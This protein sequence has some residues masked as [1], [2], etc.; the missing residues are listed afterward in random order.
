MSDLTVEKQNLFILFNT[1]LKN[2]PLFGFENKNIQEA[3][4]KFFLFKQKIFQVE[5]ELTIRFGFETLKINDKKVPLTN[6]ISTLL[7]KLAQD[8]ECFQVNIISLERQLNAPELCRFVQYF[9]HF[10]KN[11]EQAQKTPTE[12]FDF[13]MEGFQSLKIQTLQCGRILEKQSEQVADKDDG[14]FA[15]RLYFR[16][17]SMV[18]EMLQL[19]AKGEAFPQ[20]QMR[21]LIQSLLQSLQKDPYYLLALTHCKYFKTDEVF[22]LVNTSIF[23]SLMGTSLDLPRSDLSDLVL[24][25]FLHDIGSSTAYDQIH[26]PPSDFLAHSRK[27]TGVALKA[28]ASLFQG[29]NTSEALLRSVVVAVECQFKEKLKNSKKRS[30]YS[31]VITIASDYD[32]LLSRNPQTQK[33]KCTPQEA[34]NYLHAH[35]KNHHL[36]AYD[37]SLFK[38]FFQVIGLYPTG[39]LVQLSNGAYALIVAQQQSLDLLN[40]PFVRVFAEASGQ[41]QNEIIDLSKEETL[42][43]ARFRVQQSLG[44]DA[45][46]LGL[47]DYIHLVLKT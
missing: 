29:E 22:H 40:Q 15:L 7:Q 44:F 17:A 25:S 28:I 31:R 21:T 43:P 19:L 18:R 12:A 47:E 46:R 36:D 16:A 30:L 8:T 13:F 3:L 37:P 23:S 39:S 34:I 2:G 14:S 10:T 4:E 35:S 32:R 20:R 26:A 9:D 24:C 11:I 45:L 42:G 5:N 33:Y 1:I 27:K 38:I 6:A 41:K